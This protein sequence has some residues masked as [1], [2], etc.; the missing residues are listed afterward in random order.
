MEEHTAV[1]IPHFLPAVGNFLRSEK[2]SFRFELADVGLFFLF[3]HVKRV[4]HFDSPNKNPGVVR[5]GSAGK[6]SVLRRRLGAEART[7]TSGYRALVCT[8]SRDMVDIIRA[9]VGIV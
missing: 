6:R 7:G 5:S 3:A 4:V 1:L 2:T 8:H 9:T